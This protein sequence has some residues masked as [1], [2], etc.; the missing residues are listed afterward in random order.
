MMSR[1]LLAI[2]A[3]FRAPAGRGHRALGCRVP[4]TARLTANARD[5]TDVLPSLRG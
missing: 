2:S 5:R 3:P 1:T 4:H